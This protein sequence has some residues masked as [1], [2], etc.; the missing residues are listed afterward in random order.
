MFAR[1]MNVIMRHRQSLS[2]MCLERILSELLQGPDELSGLEDAKAFSLDQETRQQLTKISSQSFLSLQYHS[3]CINRK[4]YLNDTLPIS[5]RKPFVQP[6]TISHNSSLMP[7][8]RSPP[9][10]SNSPQHSPTS[11]YPIPDSL[12]LARQL[13]LAYQTPL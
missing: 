7:S 3:L 13:P 12:P 10:F 11:S 4:P 1:T 6:C 5:Q 8:I 2:H 9:H